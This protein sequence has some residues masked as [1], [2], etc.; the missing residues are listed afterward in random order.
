MYTYGKLLTNKNVK[1]NIINIVAYVEGKVLSL[2]LTNFKW[3]P[4]EVRYS[5]HVPEDING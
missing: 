2:N 5:K 4:I 1:E 3:Y